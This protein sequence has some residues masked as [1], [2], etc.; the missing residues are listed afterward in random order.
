MKKLFTTT[1]LAC[2]M[3]AAIAQSSGED[4]PKVRFGLKIT[5]SLNWYK[6]D[7][8]ILSG[9]GLNL[10]Y[11]GGL[12]TEFRITK[13][14]AF[15]TGLQLDLEGGKVKYNNSGLNTANGN[16]V[17]YYY[18]N[19]EDRIE[20][21]LDK[22]NTNDSV[23]N[24]THNTY[25]LSERSYKVT[26]ITIPLNL[27]LKT[28]EIGMMTY[29]G[30]VGMNFSFRWKAF[31]NDKL[32]NLAN[33]KNEEKTKINITKD[34]NLMNLSLNAGLGTEINI[35]GST[36]VLIGINYIGGF[37]SATKKE[38]EYLMKRVNDANG[39]I[40]RDEKLPQKTKSNAVLLTVGILF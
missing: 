32:T 29:Y 27:K 17:L 36:S 13:V 31:A 39:N 33:S 26:Y 37:T 15:Q 7:G 35:S 9:N 23:F 10:R 34:M 22:G 6:P 21:F 2:S 40:L 18:Y 1:L 14:A 30:Q 24:S 11:G 3:L 28:K 5:P 25:L 12:I 4:S 8:K 19:T 38:S 20:K 16:N